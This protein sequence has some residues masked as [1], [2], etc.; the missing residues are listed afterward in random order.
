MYS[1]YTICSCADFGRADGERYFRM[2]DYT[3]A[4][5]AGSPRHKVYNNLINNC[6]F[7]VSSEYNSQIV[8]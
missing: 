4:P 6:E 7:L 1:Q 3:R 8:S 5:L 2:R